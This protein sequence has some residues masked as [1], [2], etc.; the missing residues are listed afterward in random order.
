MMN[1]D[2]QRTLKDYD[3]L[4]YPSKPFAYTQPDRQKT[5]LSLFG[6]DTP[7]LSTARVLEIGCSY[8]GNILSFALANPNAEVIGIDL[9]EHQIQEGQKL[10]EYLGL[11]N[12]KLYHKNVMDFDHSFG[13]FDYI[14]C[15]GV[16]SWVSEIVQ[17][18]ILDV[19]HH[20][21]AENGSAIISYNT[22]PGWKKIEVLKDIMQLRVKM[23]QQQD[24]TIGIKDKVSYGKG[25]LEFLEKHSILDEDIK[26][27]AEFIRKK[28]D[29][30]I[31]HEYYEA[32]NHP[33]YL[34]EFDK[35]LQQFDLAYISDSDLSLTFP[36]FNNPEIE[37]LL[38]N[39]CGDNILHKEQYYD[40]M[41]NTQFRRSIITHAR[42]KEKIHISKDLHI[43]NIKNLY[44]FLKDRNVESQDELT[45]NILDNLKI[46]FPQ[47]I[48][49]SDF[50][51]KY[52]ADQDTRTLYSKVIS[53][54][55]YTDIIFATTE[56]RA[57]I[58]EEKINVSKAYR[59]SINYL[60]NISQPIIKIANFQGFIMELGNLE[61]QVIQLLDGTKTDDDIA[62]ILLNNMEKD[63]SKEEIEQQKNNVNQ[64][65]SDIRLFIE[66]NYMNIPTVE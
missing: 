38:T 57:I 54:L 6:F 53:N 55:I 19:I 37:T 52:Y 47:M 3:G 23:L 50:I 8:G 39:E 51:E 16:F 33:M 60:L 32:Y 48:K 13:K 14:I 17:D 59:K 66:K 46:E 20:H 41:K 30:Y 4:P 24:I 64:F 49:L 29:Y 5:I 12:I 27:Y 36:V 63:L 28:D 43:E 1:T 21:L 26:E 65:V 11:K 58:K 35:R 31:Y 22:Y 15:H 9:S 10:I 44:I 42:N 61:S 40:F 45:K 18:K 62:K 2:F 25:A 7:P 56:Y 34:Y